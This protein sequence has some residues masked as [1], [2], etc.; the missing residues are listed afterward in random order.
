M[1]SSYKLESSIG[2][3][4]ADTFYDDWNQT[5]VNTW[6]DLNNEVFVDVEVDS[7]EK[8]LYLVESHLK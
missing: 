3:M 7:R 4:P 8:N 2:W 6:F 1:L 5:N